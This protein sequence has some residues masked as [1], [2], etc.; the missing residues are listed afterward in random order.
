MRYQ[1]HHAHHD[2][3]GSDHGYLAD[4]RVVGPADQTEHE[5]PAK[6]EAD[7]QENARPKYT[8]SEGRRIGVAVQCQAGCDRDD[9]PADRVVDNGGSEQR[10]SHLAAY[11]LHLAHDRRH[12]LDGGTESAVP[13]NNEV[14]SR[15]SGRGSIDSGRNS[16]S[17]T[18][19]VK[20]TAI[21]AV[22]TQIAARLALL[23]SL[24]SV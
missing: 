21:P 7:H 3:N 8:L 14:I 10:H 24:R 12:D 20:G 2:Q 16:P 13:R 23:T 6:R 18:P 5:A 9:G 17:V 19:S 1:R 11:E 22:D 4:E 15:S